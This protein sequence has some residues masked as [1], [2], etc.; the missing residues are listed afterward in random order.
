MSG[1]TAPM[2][3]CQDMEAFPLPG[4]ASPNPDLFWE[5]VGGGVVGHQNIGA[6]PQDSPLTQAE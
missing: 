2:G 3:Q 6:L 1:F 4:G 5:L